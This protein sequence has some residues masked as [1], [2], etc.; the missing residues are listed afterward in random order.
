MFFM[1]ELKHFPLA[2][3]RRTLPKATG[4]ESL[5]LFRLLSVNNQTLEIEMH[6][7]VYHNVTFYYL[8]NKIIM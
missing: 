2:P 1:K 7:S 3:T 6:T 8:S 5:D 4:T